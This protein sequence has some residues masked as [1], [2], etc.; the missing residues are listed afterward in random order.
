M[1]SALYIN[2]EW[3]AP[4]EPREI[5]VFNPATE[6]VL[7]HVLAGGPR[8]VDTAVAAAHEALPGWSQVG[9][10]VR[11][12]FLQAIAAKLRERAEELAVLS[13]QNNGKPLAEARVDKVIGNHYSTL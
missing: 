13:S 9:G 8:D 12:K 10:N 3:R 5:A 4:S 7:H 1:L 6:E 2:G 11:S